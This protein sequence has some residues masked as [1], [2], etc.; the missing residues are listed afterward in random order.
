VTSDR[1]WVVTSAAPL[2][3]LVK[4]ELPMTPESQESAQVSVME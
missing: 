2:S 4:L 1:E 3:V